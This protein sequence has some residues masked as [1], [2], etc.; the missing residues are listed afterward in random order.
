MCLT[1]KSFIPRIALRNKV[2]YKWCINSNEELI[3]YFRKEKVKLGK[4]YTGE[5]QKFYKGSILDF[6][7]ESLLSTFISDGFIHSFNNLKSAYI[8]APIYHSYDTLNLV[9]CTI[10]KFT[11]YF[12]GKDGEIASRKLRYDKILSI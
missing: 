1:K 5:F 11:L 2:T 7:I 10:P 6:I 4:V 9:K 3:T 8:H 12:I